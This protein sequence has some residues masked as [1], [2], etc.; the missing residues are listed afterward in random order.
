MYPAFTTDMLQGP[1]SLS[2]DAARLLLL[3]DMVIMPFLALAFYEACLNV[4]AS[5]GDY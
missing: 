2:K 1:M 3:V 5:T 4:R